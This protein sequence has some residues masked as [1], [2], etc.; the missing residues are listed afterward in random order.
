M[1]AALLPV[2]QAR[3]RLRQDVLVHRAR[4][5]R[6]KVVKAEHSEILGELSR[7]IART[8]PMDE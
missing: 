2:F 5:E 7:L 6:F 3:D 4:L 8:A 1:S